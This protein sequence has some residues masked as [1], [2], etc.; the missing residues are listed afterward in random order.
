M[1]ED[2]TSKYFNF[3]T[4]FMN[5]NQIVYTYLNPNHEYYMIYI[6]DYSIK[7]NY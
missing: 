5:L 3:I 2:N 6:I 4:Y 1:H 7:R